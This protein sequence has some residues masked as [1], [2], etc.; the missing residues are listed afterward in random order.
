[1]KAPWYLLRNSAGEPSGTF[2]LAWIAFWIWCLHAIVLGLFGGSTLAI[3]TDVFN[4]NV[5][6]PRDFSWAS[7]LGLLPL[8][9]SYIVRKHRILDE[10][11]DE[12]ENGIP[13]VLEQK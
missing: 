4:W 1:M 12:D 3:T 7:S 13:D 9:A 10:T 2:T 6:L 8:L 11:L 5:V